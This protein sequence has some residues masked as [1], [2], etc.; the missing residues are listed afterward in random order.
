VEQWAFWFKCGTAP[1][2]PFGLQM[3]ST[4]TQLIADMFLFLIS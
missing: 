3:D 2:P 1:V 4:L